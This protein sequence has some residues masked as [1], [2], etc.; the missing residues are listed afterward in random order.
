MAELER[1]VWDEDQD[2]LVNWTID[3]VF[4]FKTEVEALMALQQLDE[5]LR[6]ARE[7]V[8]HCMRYMG[9]AVQAARRVE[10]DG[11]KVSKEAIIGHTSL[12]RQTVYNLLGED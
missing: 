8:R 10:E 3:P 9:K 2:P 1:A 12:A 6:A 11:Q 4:E 5:E 7:Q